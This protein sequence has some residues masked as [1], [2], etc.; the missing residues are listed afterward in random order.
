MFLEA[1]VVRLPM[2]PDAAKVKLAGAALTEGTIALKILG[3]EKIARVRK[4]IIRTVLLTGLE[5]VSNLAGS[6]EH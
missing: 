1:V 2:S 6:N 3:K 5:R 4:I